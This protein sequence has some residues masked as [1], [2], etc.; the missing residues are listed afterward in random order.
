MSALRVPWTNS[1]VRLDASDCERVW[2]HALRFRKSDESS[3]RHTR[4][5]CMYFAAGVSTQGT[6]WLPKA[7]WVPSS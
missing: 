3:A 4:R 2:S 7:A 1:M 6:C 5:G